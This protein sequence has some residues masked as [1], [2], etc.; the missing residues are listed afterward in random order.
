MDKN[1]IVLYRDEYPDDIWAD[2]CDACQVSRDSN[3]IKIRFN[4]EDVSTDETEE[5]A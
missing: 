1:Y 3:W 2:Y 5:E 4:P